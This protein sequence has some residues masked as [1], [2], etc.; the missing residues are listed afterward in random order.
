MI[1]SLILGLC[2]W[3]VVPILLD[4]QIKKKKYKKAIAMVCRIV[5]IVI[6]ASAVLNYLLSNI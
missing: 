1:I 3:L 2:I 6:I 5:G 4:G